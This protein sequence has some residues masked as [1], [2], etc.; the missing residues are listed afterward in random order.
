M[1]LERN[2]AGCEVELVRPSRSV[3]ARTL[4]LQFVSKVEE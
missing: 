4:A 1:R 3:Q 2:R